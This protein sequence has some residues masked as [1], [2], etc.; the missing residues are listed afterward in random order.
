MLLLSAVWRQTLILVCWGVLGGCSSATD[1]PPPATPS[2][3]AGAQATR[4]QVLSACTDFVTRL[5]EDSAGCCQQAYG[6][7]EQ[8]GCV[9]TLLRSVCRPGADAVAAGFAVYDDGAVEPCIAAHAEADAVC[10]PT[11]QD[12]LRLR[13]S[14][15]TA[16]KVL[17]GSTEAGKGCTTDVTCAEPDG[18][19]AG[20]CIGGTCRV[21]EVL[22]EGDPCPFQSGTVST[23]DAGL[24]CTTTMDEPGVC[25]RATS[26][27]GA[28]SGVLGDASCGFGNYCDPVDKVCLE[29]LNLGG[30]SCRQ[31]LECVSFDCDRITQI[32][33]PAPAIVS[34]EECFGVP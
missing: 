3:D 25:V 23:C 29:T 15:W 28:C 30:P 27:G 24:Y 17:R 5:C 21:L 33:A 19:K 11:W 9:D 7:Y 12:N 18:P 22:A 8:S 32:C 26:G 31:G 1:A 13:K 10:V 2:E 6:R 4:E 16:C 14:L 20:V 34:T